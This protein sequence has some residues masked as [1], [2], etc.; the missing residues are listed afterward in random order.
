MCN[1]LDNSV[2]VIC[3]LEASGPGLSQNDHHMR[4]RVKVSQIEVPLR[5]KLT[6]PYLGTLAKPSSQ[7][8]YVL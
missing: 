8:T 1:S 5:N 7:L 2:K 4:M 6:E 3:G